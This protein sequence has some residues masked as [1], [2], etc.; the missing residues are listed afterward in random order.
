MLEYISRKSKRLVIACMT[1][2]IKKFYKENIENYDDT[3]H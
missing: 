2:S 3:Q 1:K